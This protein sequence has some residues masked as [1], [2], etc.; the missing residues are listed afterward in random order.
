MKT[1]LTLLFAILLQSAFSQTII[2][3]PELDKFVG[4]WQCANGSTTFIIKL[5]KVAYN[6]RINNT[7]EDILM[8]THSYTVGGVVVDDTN[9]LFPTVGPNQKGSLFLYTRPYRNDLNEVHGILKDAPKH[10]AAT[11]KI[12]FLGGT[13][14]QMTFEIESLPDMIDMS[15]QY[16]TTFPTG[17]ITFTKQ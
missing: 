6:F 1:A 9:S 3:H 12:N 16:G 4:T 17:V 14:N 15:T 11:V 10:S 5:K 7:T 13:P 8:G 2:S